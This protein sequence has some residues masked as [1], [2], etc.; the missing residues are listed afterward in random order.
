MLPAT[1]VRHR[2]LLSTAFASL[3]CGLISGANAQTGSY[4][5]F[6]ED[7]QNMRLVGYNDLQGRSAYQPIVQQQGDRWALSI[8]RPVACGVLASTRSSSERTTRWRRCPSIRVWF[9]A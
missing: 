3:L 4:D 1:L 7:A 6:V 8:R 5:P 9:A 2:F